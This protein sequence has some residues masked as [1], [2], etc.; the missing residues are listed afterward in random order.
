MEGG[1]DPS[2][3]FPN[4]NEGAPPSP[5]RAFRES[6]KVGRYEPQQPLL[7]SARSRVPHTR[8]PHG[9]VE[10]R[11]VD[12][13][14]LGCGK[15]RSSTILSQLRTEMGAPPSPIRA[16]RESVKVGR[17]EPQQPLLNSVRSRVPHTRGPHGQFQVRGVDISILGCGKARSST[18]LS[19]LRTEMGAPPSP[20]RAFRESVKVGS[21]APGW[22][23]D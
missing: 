8:G 12:I 18:I 9:Q 20:I 6:V 21:G 13:S 3:L 11:G 17:Y 23:T 4:H 7:N 10:V 14:I 16:F 1:P 19:Q 5:I 22:R 15:A 2:F